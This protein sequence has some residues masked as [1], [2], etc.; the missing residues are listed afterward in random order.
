M[1]L[2]SKFFFVDRTEQARSSSMRGSE[3]LQYG[4]IYGR[5]ESSAKIC[6]AVLGSD[7]AYKA[8]VG[9]FVPETGAA[10]PGRQPYFS[11]RGEVRVYNQLVVGEYNCFSTV[12]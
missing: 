5:A 10:G 3:A 4:S 2:D 8:S 1:W 11:E 6:G 7:R 12:G 9:R